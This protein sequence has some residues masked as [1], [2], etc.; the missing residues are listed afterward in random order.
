M[1]A[2]RRQKSYGFL[3]FFRVHRKLRRPTLCPI[4]LRERGLR[5]RLGRRADL[6]ICYGLSD[7]LSRIR[8]VVLRC[9][10]LC[11][12]G[13]EGPI[14]PARM[15]SGR[16]GS[17]AAQSGMSEAAWTM[18]LRD[19]VRLH[20]IDPGCLDNSGKNLPRAHPDQGEA[21]GPRS[22]TCVNQVVDNERIRSRSG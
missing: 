4:E 19:Q 11:R 6:T 9:A 3:R 5:M 12:R 14:R 2:D 17:A 1:I 18:E 20:R 8:C 13:A 15:L 7:A 10:A 16:N 21:P 22:M